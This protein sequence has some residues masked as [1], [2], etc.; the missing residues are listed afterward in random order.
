MY[1]SIYRGGVEPKLRAEVGI[2]DELCSATNPP[3]CQLV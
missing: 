3:S 1:K 2:R